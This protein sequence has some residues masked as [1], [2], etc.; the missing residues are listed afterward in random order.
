M[1]Q[2]FDM[3]NLERHPVRCK[4]TELSEIGHAEPV[5]GLPEQDFITVSM[6]EIETENTMS[7]PGTTI[8]KTLFSRTHPGAYNKAVEWKDNQSAGEVEGFMI[9]VP[10]HKEHL[11]LRRDRDPN[12]ATKGKLIPQINTATGKP[13]VASSMSFFVFR[14]ENVTSELRRRGTQL[15]KMKAWLKPVTTTETGSTEDNI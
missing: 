14:G 5:V 13:S 1:P 3:K 2:F 6:V 12:S 15:E 9:T 7:S 8:T 4:V 11:R 10:T